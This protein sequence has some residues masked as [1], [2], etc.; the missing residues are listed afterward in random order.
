MIGLPPSS[1]FKPIILSQAPHRV[2]VTNKCWWG[3]VINNINYLSL[4][5]KD[6]LDFEQT[7]SKCNYKLMLGKLF[8]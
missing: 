6:Y 4:Y 2:V 7:K 3:E 8:T 5:K 1:D